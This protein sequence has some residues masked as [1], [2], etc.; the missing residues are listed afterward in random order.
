MNI[1]TKRTLWLTKEEK[2]VLTDFYRNFYYDD[3]T[4]DMY[5]VLESIADNTSHPSYDIKIVN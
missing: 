5:D 1:E 2:K 3:A 4:D